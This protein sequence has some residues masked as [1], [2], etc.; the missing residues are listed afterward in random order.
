MDPEKFE[1]RRKWL[2]LSVLSHF[3]ISY[4]GHSTIF[5]VTVSFGQLFA[6]HIQYSVVAPEGLQQLLSGALRVV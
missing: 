1:M 3:R 6:E 5:A 2:R 4:S